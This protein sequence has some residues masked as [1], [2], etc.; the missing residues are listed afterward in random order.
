M[1]AQDATTRVLKRGERLL[2]PDV[3][4]LPMHGVPA[5]VKDYG[6]YRRTPLAPLARML[7]RREARTLRR[8]R[9]WRHAP[10][11]MGRVGGLALA[12]EFVPGR[13]LSE[14]QVDDGTLRRLRGALAGLHAHGYTHNDLHPANVL[15]DGERVVLLDY[16]AALRVPRWLRHAPAA[17]RAAP[18]RPGQRAEDR[19]AHHRP[20][21]GRPPRLGGGRAA[22]GDRGARRLEALLPPLQGP[23]RLTRA[24]RGPRVR[25]L[26]AR[27]RPARRCGCAPPGP[28]RTRTPCRRRSCRWPPP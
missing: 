19:A 7:V 23:H 20:R 6:R 14:G 21:P 9:G 22:L 26:T 25:R 28:G 12:M 10:R 16:T 3:Y 24:R 18:Q 15:V 13:P 11:L 1:P 2:E 27:R 5:V 17:A 4:L 8:L